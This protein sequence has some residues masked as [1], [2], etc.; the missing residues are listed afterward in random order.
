MEVVWVQQMYET[1]APFFEL[2]A[3]VQPQEVKWQLMV[4]SC[5]RRTGNQQQVGTEAFPRDCYHIMIATT[6]DRHSS[7]LIKHSSKPFNSTFLHMP[8]YSLQGGSCSGNA[9]QLKAVCS[10][11]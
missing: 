1:A 4:A 6:D 11:C 10:T 5:F 9:E 3:Q 2:A 8:G 7:Q